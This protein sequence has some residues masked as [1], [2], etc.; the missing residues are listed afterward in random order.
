MNRWKRV[1]VEPT[2]QMSEA[3]GVKWEQ[4]DGFPARWK[5]ALAVAPT[6]PAQDEPVCKIIGNVWRN[7]PVDNFG[8]RNTRAADDKLRKA[9]EELAPWMSA[10]L[11]DPQACTEFKET[12]Y[13]FLGALEQK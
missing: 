9:A 12:A 6:P 1:P 2:Y 13:A 10:A 4:G 8:I 11:E 7:A 5:A 3:M